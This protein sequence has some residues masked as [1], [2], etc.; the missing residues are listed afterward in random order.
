VGRLRFWLRTAGIVAGLLVCVPLHYLWTLFGDS[1]WPRRFLRW[2]GWAAGVR[3]RT[4]GAPLKREVLFLSNHTSWLDIMIL[5]GTTG[6]AF[7]AKD[8]VGRWPVAGW[9]ARL[10]RTVF[11]ARAQRSA[12]KGQAD[13][14][15]TALASGRPV[16]LF[17]EGT[18]DGG[19]DVLPFRASLLAALFPPLPRVLVQPVAIAFAPGAHDIAWVGDEGAGDNAR[20]VLS[21]P[22]TIPV[23]VH[24]LAPVDPA[25]A[26]DRKPLAALARAEIVAALEARES[27]GGRAS[28]ARGDRI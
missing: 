1:P 7:V 27:D 28:E 19:H 14:L 20:R 4:L 26:G 24:F 5:A 13:A 10:N 18:T 17:P 2:V 11:V 16:G 6:A 8:D 12:V 25:D 3:I 15:R 23:T 22:G 9:L 21:R